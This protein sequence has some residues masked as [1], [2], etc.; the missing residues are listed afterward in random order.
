MCK[1]KPVQLVID[2]GELAGVLLYLPSVRRIQREK[3]IRQAALVLRYPCV[4]LMRSADLRHV[5]PFPPTCSYSRRSQGLLGQGPVLP[6]RF[7]RRLAYMQD[8]VV[9]HKCSRRLQSFLDH[10]PLPTPLPELA[11]LASK[12]TRAF[13]SLGTCTT[14]N[15][16]KELF[17]SCTYSK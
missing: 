14:L 5:H 17:N 8:Q 3:A 11:S 2:H 9:C 15:E 4:W 10:C 7:L 6:R 16:T 12:S 1:P 13:C